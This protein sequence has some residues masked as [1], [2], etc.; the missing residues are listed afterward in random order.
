M[1]AYID[2]EQF[3]MEDWE[4]IV[5]QHPVSREMEAFL[6]GIIGEVDIQ[7]IEHDIRPK[8]NNGNFTC[9]RCDKRFTRKFAFE[10]HMK[11][12]SQEKMHSCNLCTRTFYRKD[13]LQQHEIVCRRK[14][15]DDLNKTQLIAYEG[16]NFT[17]PK[18]F[19]CTHCK[20]DFKR[21]FDLQ[22]HEEKNFIVARVQKHFIEKTK[23]W[24]TNLNAPGKKQ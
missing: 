1:N 20:K 19:V 7:P 6:E 17:A 21:N 24:Y 9:T 13:K 14:M 2:I 16:N 23:N 22:R 4:E 12:H 10:R 3:T 8:N 5:R 15:S 11:I 18:R